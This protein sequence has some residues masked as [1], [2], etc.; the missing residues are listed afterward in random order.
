V[1]QQQIEVE[2]G[3][4]GRLLRGVAALCL[5]GALLALGGCGGIEFKGKIFDYMGLSGDHQQQDV[6]MAAQPPLVVPPNTQYL[7]PPGSEPVTPANQ[8]WPTNPETV[9]RELAQ[10][11]QQ[12]QEKEAA[13]DDPWNPYAGKPS[14]LSKLWHRNKTPPPP[15]DNVPSPDPSDS[16]PPVNGGQQTAQTTGYKP[17]TD[18][19][20]EAPPEETKSAPPPLPT[21]QGQQDPFRGM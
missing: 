4:L 18:D 14:L 21:S 3:R 16:I 15:V 13:A 12:Q 19:G 10:K 6:K 11:K 8:Q 17:P 1:G 2:R 20:L 7:P 9:A 5:G